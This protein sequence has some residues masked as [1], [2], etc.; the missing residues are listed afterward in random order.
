MLS[1]V[2]RSTPTHRLFVYGT[3]L[4]GEREHEFM[5][6]AELLGSVRTEPLYT[7]VELSTLAALVAGGNTAVV[8]EL[9]RISP[10]HRFQL[11]VHREHPRLFVREPVRL[12]GGAVAEAYFMR[13]D[14]VRGFRRV[15]GGDWKGRFAPRANAMPEN[16]WRRWDRRQ[17]SRR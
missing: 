4:P 8:G 16:P 7:L 12:E 10:K 3:L 2:S 13:M 1:S 5:C 17:K 15:A 6:G 9:Y 14:Q 11:D